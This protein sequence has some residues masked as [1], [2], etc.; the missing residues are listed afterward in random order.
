VL[1][2][3]WLFFSESDL[4]ALSWPISFG[5]ETITLLSQSNSV[6][7][8]KYWSKMWSTNCDFSILS[9]MVH[10]EPAASVNL[11][12]LPISGGR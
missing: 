12:K 7:T 2:W 3:M 8:T 10:Y 9:R 6:N 11:P 4:S 5:R 1:T